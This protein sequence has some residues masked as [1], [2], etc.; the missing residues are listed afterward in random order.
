MIDYEKVI[1]GLDLKFTSQR[2]VELE[3]LCP[4]H[5]ARTGKEDNHPSWWFNTDNGMHLCF[6]CGYKGNIFTLVRDL[7]GIDYFDAQ[8][9]VNEQKESTADYLLARLRDLPVYEVPEEPLEMSEARLAVFTEPPEIELRKRFLTSDAARKCGVLWDPKTSAWILPIRNPE[10]YNLWGWQEKGAQ[11]RFFKNQPGGVKKSKSM[12]NIENM[13]TDTVI[14]VESPLDVVRLESVGYTGAVSPYGAALSDSQAKILRNA[15]T[16][17]AAYDKDDA[18]RKASEEI[19]K[20][21]H[22]YGMNLTF[23]N[24]NG[25]DV[26][27]IGD[28]TEEQIHWG[29]KHARHM[30][31]GKAAYTWI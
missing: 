21:A 14:I 3:G 7:K 29:I 22:T 18:G 10:N 1:V 28:M 31:E 26:K 9:F 13:S 11:G 6:S 17:M 12:F 5:K 20:F 16:I 27:D 30:V 25:I 4:M 23:F 19:V 2:G 8:E 24:Y 15:K